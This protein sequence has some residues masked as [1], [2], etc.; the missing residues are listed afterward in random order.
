MA[1][2][3]KPRMTE[4]ELRKLPVSV[5]L[6]DAGRAFCMG[7]TKTHELV[8]RGEF[9]CKVLRLGGGYVVP[10]PELLRVLGFP[11]PEIQIDPAT[12]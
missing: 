10:K 8:R 1:D 2:A 6:V 3:A 4:D 5:P 11:I 7:R 12:P 9:P